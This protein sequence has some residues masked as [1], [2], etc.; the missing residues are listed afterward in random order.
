MGRPDDLGRLHKRVVIPEPSWWEPA[1]PFLYNASVE[2]WEA[3]QFCDRVEKHCGLRV[4][5]RGG[6]D[7]L[8]NGRPIE[9][10]A[11]CYDR[12]SRQEL[13]QLHQAGVNTLVVEVAET[14]EEI[15]DWADQLGFLVI[16]RLRSSGEFLSPAVHLGEHVCVLGWILEPA[17]FAGDSDYSAFGLSDEQGPGRFVG[18]QWCGVE[19]RYPEGAQFVLCTERDVSAAIQHGFPAVTLVEPP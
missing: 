6:R 18:V 4:L 8:L 13:V 7:F 12:Q 11:T 15:W 17:A 3:E 1:S 14:S 9:A 2:L 5:R 16:G 10:R 19:A